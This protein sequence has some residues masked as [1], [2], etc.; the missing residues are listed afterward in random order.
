MDGG[1]KLRVGIITGGGDCPGLNAGIRAVV[2][3]GINKNGWEV[4]GIREGWKGLLGDTNV[5]PLGINDVSGILH[6]G[7]TMLKTSRTNPF[8]NADN[9]DELMRNLKNLELDCLVAIGGDNNVGIGQKL[10]A[11]GVENVRHTKKDSKAI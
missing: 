9:P 1:N 2:R 3:K 10:G 4:I 8:K 7:G 11:L 5:Q 6:R